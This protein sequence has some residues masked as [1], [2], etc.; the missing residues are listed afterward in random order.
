MPVFKVGNKRPVHL[1]PFSRV[2]LAIRAVRLYVFPTETFQLAPS[3][4]PFVQCGGV[5]TQRL[6]HFSP[7]NPPPKQDFPVN[8]KPPLTKVSAFS[9]FLKSWIRFLVR[10]DPEM[11]ATLFRTWSSIPKTPLISPVASLSF[12]HNINFPLSLMVLNF[13]R[14]FCGTLFPQP[15]VHKYFAPRVPP[16]PYTPSPHSSSFRPGAPL[17]VRICAFLFPCT[18]LTTTP[19]SSS[20]W[21]LFCIQVIPSPL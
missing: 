1:S 20:F 12:S 6:S 14:H 3:V 4:F 19:S 11:S 5:T 7:Q 17:S 8:V 21:F 16:P 10:Y 15:N 13:F 2:G 18:G 9:F